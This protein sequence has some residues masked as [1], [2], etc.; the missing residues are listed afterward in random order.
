MII[1]NEVCLFILLSLAKARYGYRIMQFIN[2]KTNKDIDD[3]ITEKN[4]DYGI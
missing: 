2:E 1:K 4:T 3:I